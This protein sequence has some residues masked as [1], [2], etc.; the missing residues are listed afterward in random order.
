M[1][2]VKVLR[3]FIVTIEGKEEKLDE[4]QAKQKIEELEKKGEEL[5]KK[6][7][8]YFDMSKALQGALIPHK[9][10]SAPKEMRKRFSTR[11][12][13]DIRKVLE[14]SPDTFFH[15]LDV[16][17]KIGISETT[18]YMA[19]KQMKELK[20]VSW[21]KRGPKILYRALARHEP[22]SP[23]IPSVERAEGTDLSALSKEEEAKREMM[24]D[25]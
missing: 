22:K 24:R 20:A 9:Y 5:E 8:E 2:E 18:V 14:S 7:K 16:A 11:Y 12:M 17:K 23:K 15:P 6:A 10:P 21:T 3:T 13:E 19:L 1:V 4:E 25:R